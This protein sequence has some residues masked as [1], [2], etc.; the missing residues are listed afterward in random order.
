MSDECKPIDVEAVRREV[1]E[2]LDA[3]DALTTERYL[4]ARL[5]GALEAT[6]VALA[7][8]DR[9]MLL[10]DESKNWH[11]GEFRVEVT[12]AIE[13]AHSALGHAFADCIKKEGDKPCRDCAEYAHDAVGAP[14]AAAPVTCEAWCG[15]PRH[16]APPDIVY[17]YKGVH[18]HA[19]DP[20]YCQL[21]CRDAGKPLHPPLPNPGKQR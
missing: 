4:T 15:G 16:L 11:Y 18:T 9:A 6:F 2:L 3:K 14:S 21:A 8:A 12:A 7:R 17:F 5:R 1:R 10:A 19:M 20:V 13:R